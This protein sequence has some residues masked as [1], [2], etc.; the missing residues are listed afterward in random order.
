[1]E[2][3]HWKKIKVIIAE[4]QLDETDKV[5]RTSTKKWITD[6]ILD[7]MENQCKPKGNPTQ[8]KEKNKEIRRFS[9]EAKENFKSEDYEEIEQLERIYDSFNLY[10]KKLRKMPMFI[11][12]QAKAFYTMTVEEL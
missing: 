4:I 7:K 1:M 3:I 2:K 5:K 11:G 10:I 9:R 8:Y 12:Y 6:E